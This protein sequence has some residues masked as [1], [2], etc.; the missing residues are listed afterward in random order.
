MRNEEKFVSVLETESIVDITMLKSIL[1]TENV[2]Y[3][4]QGE[5]MKFIEPFH[6]V[7]KLM[8]AEKD[9]Q[10]VREL[11]KPIKLSYVRYTKPY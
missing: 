2:T 5:N 3:F 7:A 1:D 4:I 10:K 6:Q 8:V 11:L 9:V